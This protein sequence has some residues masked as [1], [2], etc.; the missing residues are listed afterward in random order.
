MRLI[1]HWLVVAVALV[2]AAYLV[3]G[4]RVE[5]DGVVAVLVMAAILGVV[6]VVIRPILAFLSCGFI[7]L[8]MGLFMLVINALTLWLSSSI[9]VNW[10][11]I[12][13]YVDGF[14]PALLGSIIVSIVSF[15]LSMV[16]FPRSR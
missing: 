16:L 6:N 15:L 4:I 14:W 1:L 2:A 9:A 5:G 8:T 3:P 12:G 7:I 11:N 13:F 10:F